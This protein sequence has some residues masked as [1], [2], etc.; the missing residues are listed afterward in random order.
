MARSVSRAVLVLCGVWIVSVTPTWA[1]DDG[2]ELGWADA[3]EFTL[4]LTGGNAESS[5][6]GFKNE[7]TRTWE[8][9][10]L[11]FD[12]NALR[13]EST[14]VTRSGLSTPTAVQVTETSL[15]SLTA[16][17]YYARGQYDREISAR[18]FWFGG[19]AWERNTFAGV[20][21]R[22][23]TSA[24]VGNTWRDTERATFKT[25]Y[26][27]SL[28]RQ[29]DVIGL[30][31]QSFPGLR[32][33]TDYRQQL[34]ANTEFVSGLIVDQNLDETGDIR[35]DLVNAVTVNMSSVLALS[36][37]WR[38]LFDRQPSLI[39]V[40]LVDETGLLTGDLTSVEAAQVDNFLTFGLVAS[41]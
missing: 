4:V 16:A 6:L 19:A 35:T 41:F 18:T 13:A 36:I 25:S 26:G 11:L 38:L 29:E 3:A 39:E 9:A 5:A 21:H 23:T 37:R 34:T 30:G 14:T 17:N 12:V 1:Q 32:L 24:G 40:P 7:L 15:S 8:N 2:P 28:I 22:Y 10:V 33:S 31:I 20:A 27:V